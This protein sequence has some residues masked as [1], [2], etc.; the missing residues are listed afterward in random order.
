MKL[1]RPRTLAL[2]LPALLLAGCAT[3]YVVRADPAYYQNYYEALSRHTQRILGSGPIRMGFQPIL[4][5]GMP[6]GVG[7]EEAW[8]FGPD[9]DQRRTLEAF[10]IRILNASETAVFIDPQHLALLTEKG[11]RFTV[12]PLTARLRNP[13]RAQL[14]EPQQTFQGD[15]LFELPLEGLKEDPQV[16]LVYEDPAG[17][18]AVRY[19][20]TEEMRRF[21]GL[22]LPEMD[23]AYVYYETPPPYPYYPYPYY[24]PV[25][26]WWYDYTWWGPAYWAYPYYWSPFYFGVHI[27]RH[28]GVIPRDRPRFDRPERPPR[29]HPRPR[30]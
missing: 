4:W 17:H 26:Y 24:A 1:L 15:V 7:P 13:W 9:Q 2:L 3:A 21:E 30:R 20:R 22:R 25:P 5:D 28:R 8:R 18:R 10:R 29:D 6:E 14:V 12:S 23:R 19:V 27:D 16:K 11:R